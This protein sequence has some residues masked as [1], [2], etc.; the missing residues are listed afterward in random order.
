M[1]NPVFVFYFTLQLSSP[2]CDSHMWEQDTVVRTQCWSSEGF[3][4]EC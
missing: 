3:I 2:Q 4:Y 1:L